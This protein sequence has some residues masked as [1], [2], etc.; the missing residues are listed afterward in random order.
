[1]ITMSGNYSGKTSNMQTG[2]EIRGGNSAS[3][4]YNSGPT[5]TAKAK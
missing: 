2:T 4:V 3:G 1:M 5:V